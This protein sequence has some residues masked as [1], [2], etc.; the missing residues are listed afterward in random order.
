M[1][2]RRK[3]T[4]DV[5]PQNSPPSSIS[6]GHNQAGGSENAGEGHQPSRLERSDLPPWLIPELDHIVS[7]YLAG[8]LHHALLLTG[9]SGLGKGLLAKVL[10]RAL[11]CQAKLGEGDDSVPTAT[12]LPCGKCR[13][14]RLSAGE[15]HPDMRWLGPNNSGEHGEIVV[16]TVRGL[17]EFIHLSA[18]FGGSRVAVIV[19]CERLNRSAANSLLKILEEP[20]P[21]VFLIL[22]TGHPGRLPATIRSRCTIRQMATPSLEEA[23]YWLASQ[24]N[25][26]AE[27][28]RQ[29][30][31]LSGGMP[32]SADAML[33][34]HGLDRLDA[35]LHQLHRL[36]AG[37]DPIKEAETWQDDPRA[38]AEM[39]ISVMAELI[40][41]RH[42]GAMHG[43]LPTSLG[44]HLAK[45]S[46]LPELHHA[47]EQMTA[48]RR[49]LDQP[50][51]GRLAAEAIFIDL[52]MAL[53]GRAARPAIHR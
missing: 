7:H 24:H 27:K 53:Q 41:S 48:H 51:Q 15:N 43:L 44:E 39:L 36:S 46:A 45:S 23:Q 49:H 6:Q 20:P 13:A 5:K 21:G 40:R 33:Q 25:L 8:R 16:E 38:L 3:K 11:L 10:A 19:P 30:L 28:L 35:L 29:A 31:V 26:S 14:C 22:A 9:R 37:S 17:V 50:L 47:F 32:F 34:Q 4:A 52:A 1:V 42:G 18:Q 12:A 2:T